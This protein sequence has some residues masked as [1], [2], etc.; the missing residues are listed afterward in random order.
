[1]LYYSLQMSQFFRQ[2][3]HLPFS[4]LATLEL[5]AAAEA[6]PREVEM[7]RW[8]QQKYLDPKLARQPLTQGQRLP[9]VVESNL[10]RGQ[11]AL[12]ESSH[13][14]FEHSQL[15]Q[16]RY[17]RKR[18]LEN[19]SEACEHRWWDGGSQQLVVGR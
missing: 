3:S 6:D 14:I 18:R 7:Y 4:G 19:W 17:L 5:M 15:I 2:G 11:V 16:K 9:Q 8:G 13:P 1:M 10:P 12:H